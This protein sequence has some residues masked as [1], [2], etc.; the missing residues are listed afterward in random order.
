[1]PQQAKQIACF[2]HHD[3]RVAASPSPILSGDP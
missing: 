2:L 3:A 1:M